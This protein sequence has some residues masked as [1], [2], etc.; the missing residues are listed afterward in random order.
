MKK[1]VST[2]AAAT[3]ATA[4]MLPTANANE[5][6]DTFPTLAL[7]SSKTGTILDRPSYPVKKSEPVKKTKP[8]PKPTVKETPAPE[9]TVPQ[10][11]ATPEVL[12]VPAETPTVA[13]LPPSGLTT[14]GQ[15]VSSHQA[16]FDWSIE[17]ANGSAFAYVKATEGIGYLNPSYQMQYTGAQAQGLLTGSYHFAQPTVSSGAVQAETFLQNSTP[18]TPDGKTL[19]GLLDMEYNLA[20]PNN[21]CYGMSS[22]E[23]TGWV[24]DF[25][26]TYKKATGRAPMVYS[27]TDWWIKCTGNAVL[28]ADVPFYVAN[29]PQAAWVDVKVTEPSKSKE[30]DGADAMKEGDSKAGAYQDKTVKQKI[31]IDDAAV[32]ASGA[33][34]PLPGGRT[35]IDFWQYSDGGKFQGDSAVFNGSLEELQEFANNKN[36]TPKTYSIPLGY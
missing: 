16:P 3:M 17:Q 13:P 8:A 30:K 22:A 25:I 29:Y 1:I 9:P 7:Y 27:T 15:D 18:W 2:L 20:D 24:S 4:V 21:Q 5:T 31:I 26:N 32:V 28:P 34:G 23:M 35:G 10:E 33:V 11:E 19:P 14:Y 6:Y 12:P 36:Y